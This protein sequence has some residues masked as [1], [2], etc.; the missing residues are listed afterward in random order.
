MSD[1]LSELHLDEDTSSSKEP[2]DRAPVAQADHVHEPGLDDIILSGERLPGEAT[3][4]P[5]TLIRRGT[6]Q[7]RRKFDPEKLGLLANTIEDKGLNN[8][9]IVRPLADGTFELIAGERRFLAHELLRKD[10]IY[11][12][13]RNLSDAEAAILS[14]TDNDARKTLLI[15]SEVRVTRSFSMTRL[16]NPRR[17]FPAVSAVAWP[18]SAAALLISSC[19]WVSFHC[20][21]KILT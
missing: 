9:I 7:P 17:S 4:L 8:A 1:V 16:C 10:H 20:W 6:Y 18:R 14:V 11:A 12:L 19:L 15:S 5:L 13:I 2:L 3:F 21:K